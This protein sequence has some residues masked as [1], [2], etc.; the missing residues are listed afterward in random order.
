MIVIFVV[1]CWIVPFPVSIYASSK[2]LHDNLLSA[3]KLFWLLFPLPIICYWLYTCNRRPN[4]VLEHEELLS[5]DVQDV[6]LIMEGPFRMLKANGAEKNYRLPWEA[7][8][9]GRRLVLILFKTFIINTFIRLS[10]MMLYTAL[11]LIHHIYTKPFSSSFLNNVET[12]SLLMLHIICFLNL[13][14]AYH[15]AYPMYSPD[16]TENIIHTL[17]I[18]E[19]TLNLVFPFLVVTVVAIFVFTRIIQFIYLL[20]QC[21]VRFIRF[22]T[23]YKLP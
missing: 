4:R 22:C 5:Q 7:F 18:I 8:L 12:T 15:Y 9:I 6:L 23:K 21:F 13:I 1:C 3:K 10:F 11:F 14:P 2:L 17:K 20:C 16:H 19:T